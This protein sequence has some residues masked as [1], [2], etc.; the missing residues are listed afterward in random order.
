MPRS[1]LFYCATYGK[2]TA[3]FTVS[4][5][6]PIF[7]VSNNLADFSIS[8]A[9]ALPD[10]SSVSA[11]ELIAEDGGIDVGVAY[12][13]FGSEAFNEPTVGNLTDLTITK[14]LAISADL[15]GFAEITGLEQRYSVVP[16]PDS[17]TLLLLGLTGERGSPLVP[18][19]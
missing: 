8:S 17:A 14:N 4:S 12:T 18:L 15:G 6:I 10:T 16:E 1:L 7:A 2:G 5:T 3:K 11:S 9:G 19:A 13:N